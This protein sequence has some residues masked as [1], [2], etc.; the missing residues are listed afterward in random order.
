MDVDIIPSDM[1]RNQILQQLHKFGFT[2]SQARLYLA[3][4]TLGKVLMKHLA[5]EAGV[6]R[7]TAY[8]IM[9]ELERRGFF[10]H[11]KTGK[12]TYY[13]AVSPQELLNMT[14]HREQL[15]RSI[16]PNLKIIAKQ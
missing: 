14:L 7:G 8:Y 4:L 2:A 13:L 5:K 3:G 6:S 15:V 12:R 10:L 9:T 16:L 11:K 1:K